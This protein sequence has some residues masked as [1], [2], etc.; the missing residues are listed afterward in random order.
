MDGLPR[1]HTASGSRSKSWRQLTAFLVVRSR[2]VPIQRH[3]LASVQRQFQSSPGLLPELAPVRTCLTLFIFPSDLYQHGL[4]LQVLLHPGVCDRGTFGTFGY[5]FSDPSRVQI[6]APIDRVWAV[7]TNFDNYS[8]WNPF[9]VHSKLDGDG[10]KPRL[11][12]SFTARS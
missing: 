12:S 5:V 2:L 4:C 10:T 6:D 7:L 11:S 9:I 1:L 8:K 3:R